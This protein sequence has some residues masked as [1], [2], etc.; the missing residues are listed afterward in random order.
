MCVVMKGNKQPATTTAMVINQKYFW[1]RQ[2][3]QQQQ[4]YEELENHNN[5][6]CVYFSYS[7]YLSRKKNRTEQ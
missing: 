1:Q 2:R 3:Q 7:I 5:G 6:F 4:E